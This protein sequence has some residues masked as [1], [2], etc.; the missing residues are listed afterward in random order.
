MVAPLSNL[1]VFLE[2]ADLDFFV[3]RYITLIV[4]RLAPARKKVGVILLASRMPL[5]C[6]VAVFF[7][8]KTARNKEMSN[9]S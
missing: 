4:G 8:K 5:Y 3:M 7:V 2:G 1:N 6:L 9:V